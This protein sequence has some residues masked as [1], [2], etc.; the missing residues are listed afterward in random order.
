MLP[1]METKLD[2]P[3]RRM[4]EAGYRVSVAEVRDWVTGA[5]LYHALAIDEAGEY[6]IVSAPTELRA[7]AE[8]AKELGLEDQDWSAPAFLPVPKTRMCL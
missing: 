7:L 5:T 2:D 6:R 3:V 1:M 4:R 8:L